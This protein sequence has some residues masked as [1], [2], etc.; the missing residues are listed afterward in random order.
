MDSLINLRICVPYIPLSIS[1]SGAMYI[2][3]P[4]PLVR[5][6]KSI[7]KSI[8]LVFDANLEVASPKSPILIRLPESK[9]MFSGCNT[10]NE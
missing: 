1:N 3:V 4:H 6:S 9:N 8:S 2:L 7:F 10:N 5:G